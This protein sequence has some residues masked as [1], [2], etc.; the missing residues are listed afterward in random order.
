MTER[1]PKP[2]DIKAARLE[3][4]LTQTEAGAIVHS[5]CRA[6]QYWESGQRR[7]H[8]ATWELFETKTRL[9]ASIRRRIGE[10]TIS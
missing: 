10:Q 7:M 1:Y 5:T 6:W 2:E 3:A 4:G 9:T 8:P